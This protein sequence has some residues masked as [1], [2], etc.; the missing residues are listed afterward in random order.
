MAIFIFS[1][2]SNNQIGSLYRIASSQSIYDEHKNW[3]DDM[4]DLVTVNDIDF[5]EV[6]LNKKEVLFKNENQ[7]TYKNTYKIKDK[8]SLTSY[9]KNITPLFEEWITLNSSKSITPSVITY[10]NYIKSI[11][12]PSLNISE[13]TP[14]ISLENYV[15]DQGISTIHTLQLL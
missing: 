8:D 14:L 15:E 2:N 7:V 1:K 9:I 4:Y 5:N 11:D 12:V 3:K 6:R 13:E 10:L